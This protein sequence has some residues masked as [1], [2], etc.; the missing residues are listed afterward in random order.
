M[1]D[2]RKPMTQEEQA[3]YPGPPQRHNRPPVEELQQHILRG[4]S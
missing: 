3:D 4:W 2:E 1:S